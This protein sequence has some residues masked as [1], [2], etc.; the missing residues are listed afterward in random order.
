MDTY[1]NYSR[2][3]SRIDEISIVDDRLNE[4]QS[5]E[6][7]ALAVVMDTKTRS[8]NTY[9][10]KKISMLDYLWH[11]LNKPRVR[12]EPNAR[13]LN[14]NT[15]A[16]SSE[17]VDTALAFMMN[18]FYRSPHNV[19]I[20]PPSTEDKD[21]CALMERKLEYD[22]RIMKIDNA[23]YASA[24]QALILG[25]APALV[26]L[27][28]TKRKMRT[29]EEDIR[30]VIPKTTFEGFMIEPIDPFD[31]FPSPEKIDIDDYHPMIRRTFRNW[32]ELLESEPRLGYF[33]LDK[34]MDK[35][36]AIPVD[37][38]ETRHRRRE[39]FKIGNAQDIKPDSIEVLEWDGSFP[40]SGKK[41]EY[42]QYIYEPAILTVAN[43]SLIGM[44][45]N[46]NLSGKNNMVMGRIDYTPGNF[47]PVGMVEKL[48]AQQHQ[49]NTLQDLILDNLPMITNNM[50]L[51]EEDA[52]K[53]N[54]MFVAR[55]NGVITVSRHHTKPIDQLVKRMKQEPMPDQVFKFYYE[56]ITRAEMQS[57]ATELTKGGGKS[58]IETAT[59]SRQQDAWGSNRMELNLRLFEKSFIQP[60]HAYGSIIN[61]DLVS[62]SFVEKIFPGK[63][64]LWTQYQDERT[65]TAEPDFI[66]LAS[67]RENDERM[68]IQQIHQLIEIFKGHPILEGGILFLGEKIVEA[69]KWVDAEPFLYELRLGW[70]RYLAMQKAKMQGDPSALPVD[71]SGGGGG[72]NAVASPAA[73]GNGNPN[74]QGG[75]VSSRPQN[76]GSGTS[77]TQMAKSLAASFANIGKR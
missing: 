18:K 3:T 12:T 23:I 11:Y 21:Y 26:R 70:A 75:N 58:S 24:K 77:D 34:I 10:Q 65:L 8:E 25:A 45:P 50:W 15:V 73:G 4:G 22:N 64:P 63:G 29:M 62:P 35:R 32:E 47:W 41:D 61:Q 53:N 66:A 46:N 33:D 42:D 49:A 67:N 74:P 2:N 56:T 17:A 7:S 44:K 38:M 68:L 76:I 28:I 54:L 59:E 13:M 37:L 14:N 9:R 27:E 5:L 39:L 69:Y 72:G 1:S 71:V 19:T 57:G 36:H 43:G 16:L 60:A 48:H 52:V 40:V 30:K 20:K 51:V 31:L 55:P 6:E